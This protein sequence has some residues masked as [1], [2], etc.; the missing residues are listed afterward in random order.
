MDL[1]GNTNNDEAG[2]DDGAGAEPVGEGPEAGAD[3]QAAES[4]RRE[5]ETGDDHAVPADLL[6]VER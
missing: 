5:Q 1:A 2:E 6:V 4:L 3:E